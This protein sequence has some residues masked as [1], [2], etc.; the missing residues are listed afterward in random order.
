MRAN[1]FSGTDRSHIGQSYS[2]DNWQT[3][4]S[5]ISVK[6][7][8]IYNSLRFQKKKEKNVRKLSNA[9]KWR[10]RA[11]SKARVNRR[12]EYGGD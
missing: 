8:R 3:A 7:S 6:I 11:K 10:K 1:I 2:V 4:V 12:S 5:Q 9:Q